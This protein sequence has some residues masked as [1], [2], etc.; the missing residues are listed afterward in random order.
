VIRIRRE[1][2]TRVLAA[3]ALMRPAPPTYDDNGIL[4]GAVETRLHETGEDAKQIARVFDDLDRRTSDHRAGKTFSY[5]HGAKGDRAIAS[6]RARTD[7]G[8][9]RHCSGARQLRTP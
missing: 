4:S 3:H 7:P 1:D 9:T 6:V 2:F 8:L 5:T